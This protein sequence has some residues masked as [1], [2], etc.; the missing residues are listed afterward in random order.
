MIVHVCGPGETGGPD[1]YRDCFALIFL[2]LFAS[3]QKEQNLL[4]FPLLKNLYETKYL[5]RPAKYPHC[6]W[7]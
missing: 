6:G 2:I 5:L 3:M 1:G 7:L 4:A